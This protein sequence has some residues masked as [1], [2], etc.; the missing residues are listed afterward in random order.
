MASSWP[1]YCKTPVHPLHYKAEEAQ[2]KRHNSADKY[3][4]IK[5][6]MQAEE[7][8]FLHVGAPPVV[9]NGCDAAA[10]PIQSTFGGCPISLDRILP[11]PWRAAFGALA[12]KPWN[13]MDHASSTRGRAINRKE[14][15]CI[16]TQR[17][18]SLQYAALLVQGKRLGAVEMHLL[19]NPVLPAAQSCSSAGP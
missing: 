3:L 2:K 10:K 18:H 1:S 8:R 13:K 12:I 19:P 11:C 17:S 7:C 6:F 15:A 14:L 5:W 16:A 4:W 9:H